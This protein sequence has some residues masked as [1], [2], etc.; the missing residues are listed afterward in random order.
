MKRITAKT[1]SMKRK[2]M[3]IA[4]TGMLAC[5]MTACGQNENTGNVTVSTSNRQY[6]AGI[7][8]EVTNVLL[9]T[10]DLFSDRDL[11]QTTDLSSATTITVSDD[12]TI[13]ITEEGIYVLQGTASDCVIMV[14]AGADAKVQLVLDGVNITNQ[15]SSVVYVESADK[16]FITT[17]D[18]D[19]TL[20]VTGGF[21]DSE[22]SG[23]AVV[24]A[25]DDLVLNGTGTLTINSAEGNGISGKDE[26]RITGGTYSIT[27][28]LDGIEANDSIAIYDG[29]ITI[30]TSKDGLHSENDEDDMVGWIYIAG[31]TFFMNVSDDVIS[32]ATFIVIDGGNFELTGSEGLEATYVQINDGEVEI[33]ASDDGIN[34]GQKSDSYSTPTIEI[35]GGILTIAVGQGDTDAIDS[36]G[37]IIINGGT[38]DITAT[39]SSFD[40]DG[41][42]QY[43]GGTIIINGTQT[44]SIPEPQMG[45]MNGG[46][47]RR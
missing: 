14:D 2:I 39:M 7:G 18:S 25:K 43:N 12:E 34:A 27:G 38:I 8:A 15:F 45:S 41:T 1:I 40:Y 42:A 11:A 31:G 35:N 37:D 4:L 33:S 6:S 24:Y 13:K 47:G 19:N 46:F 23:D 36:N 3:T 21:D 5:A 29:N 30:N 16:C 32:A 26:I 44:D 22:T 10:T 17:T 28:K 20:T 9:D